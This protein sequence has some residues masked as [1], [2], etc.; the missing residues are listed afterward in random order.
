VAR[1]I[2]VHQ[3]EHLANTDW[4][5]LIRHRSPGD[6]FRFLHA[7][8]LRSKGNG[9]KHCVVCAPDDFIN[10]WPL[11]GT[12]AQIRCDAPGWSLATIEG[13]NFSNVEWLILNALPAYTSGPERPV[14]SFLSIW[15]DVFGTAFSF[16]QDPCEVFTCYSDARTFNQGHKQDG[17]SFKRFDTQG[18][19]NSFPDSTACFGKTPASSFNANTPARVAV[20]LRC[21]SE[22]RSTPRVWFDEAYYDR[23]REFLPENSSFEF[24]GLSESMHAGWPKWLHIRQCRPFSGRTLSQQVEEAR[25]YHLA[26]GVNSSA[27]D[28]FSIAGIPVLRECEFQAHAPA[29]KWPFQ[30]R[31]NSFLAGNVNVGL[32]IPAQAYVSENK[33]ADAWQNEDRFVDAFGVMVGKLND[34][35]N[36]DVD[37][38]GT[39]RHIHFVRAKA[40]AELG[41][42]ISEVLAN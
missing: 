16:G 4:C 34:I 26:I 40:I 39:P 20:V 27:L 11:L 12:S 30:D 42:S 18:K 41:E 31:Y 32:G 3:L 5:A 19:C 17:I 25:R 24:F 35:A 23:L 22:W 37:W 6:V 21:T 28:V 8:H 15:R 10:V 13:E 1:Q 7:L 14:A 36:L 29:N 9:N 2:E 38:G 33:S